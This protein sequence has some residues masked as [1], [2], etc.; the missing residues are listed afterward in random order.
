MRETGQNRKSSSHENHAVLTF[1][2]VTVTPQQQVLSFR[3]G[4]NSCLHFHLTASYYLSPMHFRAPAWQVSSC[5][6][7]SIVAFFLG[8][9][10]CWQT[11]DGV[12]LVW[13]VSWIDPCRSLQVLFNFRQL[14]LGHH[15]RCCW[16]SA[17]ARMSQENKSQLT[18]SNLR[19]SFS[20]QWGRQCWKQPEISPQYLSAS[21]SGELAWLCPKV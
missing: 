21:M 8:S 15:V 13:R 9:Q 3:G 4:V 1:T 7:V 2:A 17:W 6:C 14:C 20:K 19:S 11:I 12:I 16:T 10:S 5:L 18:P